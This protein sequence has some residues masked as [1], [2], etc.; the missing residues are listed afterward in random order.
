MA[1]VVLELVAR[2]RR[3]YGGYIVHAS[4]VLLAIGVAGSSAY[5]TERSAR[6][7]PGERVQVADYT[8]TYRGTAAAR[9]ERA[10]AAG[11]RGRPARREVPRPVRAGQELLSGR[12]AGLER[13]GDPSDRWSLEDLFLI[14]DQSYAD[15]SI[16]LKAL[17]KP[18]VNLIW[19]AGFVFL[20][21]AVIALWPDPV[22]E[23]G[24]R[25][26]TRCSLQMTVALIVAAVL[27][28]L[29]VLYVA[30]PFLREPASRDVLAQPDELERRRLALIE[31]RDRAADALRELEFD[32][33][34]GKLSDDDYRA[35]V[36]RSAGG[37]PSGACTQPRG[38]E[39]VT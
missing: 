16:Q 19:I 6:L 25:S 14:L 39:R 5:D 4:I 34:T 35:L 22:E 9:A 23:R 28:V 33:R 10:G 26:D 20:A 12:A 37:R 30:R 36:G 2:N 8:I 27:A 24:C 18:L 32:H 7:A 29:C 15:G 31:E 21:G 38:E 1:H 3:R 11:D 13:A 17:T